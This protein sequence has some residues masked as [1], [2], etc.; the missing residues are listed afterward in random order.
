MFLFVSFV[1]FLSFFL[2]QTECLSYFILII[3]VCF[4]LFWL[5]IISL[6]SFYCLCL[7]FCRSRFLPVFQGLNFFLYLQ[8]WMSPSVFLSVLCFHGWNF[9]FYFSSYCLYLYVCLSVPL[10]LSL[11]LSLMK[12]LSS[13][14]STSHCFVSLS[15][16]SVYFFIGYPHMN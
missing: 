8:L 12:F 3:F 15:V 5:E 11:C 13:L 7:S 14:F 4:F 2:S 6:F 10:S 9:F 1:E 16:L